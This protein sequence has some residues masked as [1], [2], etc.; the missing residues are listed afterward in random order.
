MGQPEAGAIFIVK[1]EDSHEYI[2]GTFLLAASE[3]YKL[4][5]K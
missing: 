3:V 1:Q 5:N 2:S 4:N